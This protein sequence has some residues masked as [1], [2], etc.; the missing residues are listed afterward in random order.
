MVRSRPLSQSILQKWLWLSNRFPDVC[1]RRAGIKLDRLVGG[2]L[3]S[4]LLPQGREV[5]G[6]GFVAHLVIRVKQYGGSRGLVSNRE[7][8]LDLPILGDVSSSGQNPAQS[9]LQSLLIVRLLTNVHVR[10]QAEHCAAPVGTAPG[11]R[12]V[13]SFVV[14]FRLALRHIADDVVPHALRRGLSRLNTGDRFDVN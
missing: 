13:Q 2:A 14:G 6:V 5:N 11:W 10:Y 3:H 7:G 12:V 9:V 4:Q 8:P 1:Q